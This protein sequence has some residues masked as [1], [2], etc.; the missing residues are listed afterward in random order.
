MQYNKIMQE[1]IHLL[2]RRLMAAETFLLGL[3]NGKTGFSIY[4]YHQSRMTGN[5]EYKLHAQKLLTG[6]IENISRFRDYDM[7]TGL[8]GIGLGIDYLIDNKY[9]KGNINEILQDVDSELF[10]HLDKQ[11]QPDLTTPLLVYYFAVRLKKQKTGSEK[12]QIFKDLIIQGI[13]NLSEK[14]TP[15]LFEETL[16]FSMENPL[17][18]L[19]YVLSCCFEIHPV[20]IEKTL[21]ELTPYIV[22]KLPYLQ[23]N[24][25]LMLW[26]AYSINRKLRHKE[27]ETY[28]KVLLKNMDIKYMIQTEMR[29]RSIYFADGL[30]ALYFL[31]SQT[32]NCFTDSELELYNLLII[33]KIADSPEWEHLLQD[34]EYFKAMSGLYSGYC[35]TSLL[36]K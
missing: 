17:A 24:R 7:K 15:M 36:L 23:V 6:V 20:K 34:E 25:L 28:I 30:P 31:L 27:W 21:K 33:G 12:E 26:I 11:E 9:V 29:G 3:A 5:K 13:N 32:R 2:D 22:S 14:M 16:L 4:F 18:Q 8:P 10:K 19:L 1:T 35:G